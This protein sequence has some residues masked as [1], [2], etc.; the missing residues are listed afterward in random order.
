M[1]TEIIM[2]KVDMVMETGTF[3]EWLK[4]EGDPVQ[5]GE[6]I[7][8]VQTDKAAIEVE[9]PETG[10]LGGIRAKPNDVIPVTQVIGYVLQPGE[11]APAAPAPVA[12]A[13]TRPAVESAPPAPAPA[14]PSSNG[15][16]KEED[17]LTRATP[18]ARKLAKE[19]GIDLDAVQGSGP[20]GRIY[21]ADLLRAAEQAPAAPAPAMAAAL[22]APVPAPSLQVPLPNAR[23]R[24]RI[25]L[26]GPRAIIAQ[27]LS[28]SY[29]TI[30]HIYETVTVD[31]TETVRLR[32]K[33]LPIIQ[34]ATGHKVSYTAIIAT[35]VARLLGRHPGL[36]SSLNG[37]EIVQWQ[38][39]HLGIATALEDYLIVPVVRSAQERDLSGMVTEMARLLEA[40]RTKRLEPSEMSGSTFSI[41]NLGMFG[42]ESFTAIINPPEAAIL[43]VG[44]MVDTPLVVNGQVD[45]RPLMKVTLAVDHRINDGAQ[46]ARFLTDLKD[47]LENPYLLI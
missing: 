4:Q 26:R 37:D 34:Q 30:P 32:E 47:A 41:S 15:S 20:R 7:F 21:K 40:A 19:M 25:P 35:A 24:Q 27:R 43:A 14:A 42:I 45:I 46:A 28:Y 5:K 38:D 13:A 29:S 6:P 3:M 33:V 12:P 11:S 23:V 22:A 18:V 31:M 1:A 10:V 44:K 17:H 36:N 9:S 8:V 16:H 39:V 2:P